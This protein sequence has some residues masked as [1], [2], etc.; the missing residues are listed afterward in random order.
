MFI[1]FKLN[2]PYKH[3]IRGNKN[4]RKSRK[5]NNLTVGII[6]TIVVAVVGYFNTSSQVTPKTVAQNS[7]E[8]NSIDRKSTRLNSSH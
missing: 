7:Y 6:F 3:I 2:K 5:T 4:M 1:K 8:L